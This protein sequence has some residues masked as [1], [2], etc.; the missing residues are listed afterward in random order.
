MKKVLKTSLFALMLAAGLL[1]TG[2]ATIVKGGTQ[3]IKIN[4]VPDAAVVKIHDMN[5]NQ[6]V[7]SEG[8]TPHTAV[9]KK[10]AGMFKAGSYKVIVEKPGYGSKSFMI[11]GNASG[12]YIAGNLFFGGLIG[13]VVVDPITGAMWN[14]TP[15][16]I[17]ATLGDSAYNNNGDLT[18]VLKENVSEELLSKAEL[19]VEKN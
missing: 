9:L 7:V 6:N 13:W 4:S 16:Q 10:G 19:I 1:T 8:V 14:L 2:C 3:A 17:D 12:W 11:D 18:I 15:E 5:A